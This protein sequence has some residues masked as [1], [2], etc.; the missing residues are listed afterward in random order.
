MPA[1]IRFI[2]RSVRRFEVTVWA[3][4]STQGGAMSLK[5]RVCQAMVEELGRER[6]YMLTGLVRFLHEPPKGAVLITPER[7][8]RAGGWRSVEI[9]L[10]EAR[11]SP[12]S[13]AGIAGLI[14]SL[15]SSLLLLCI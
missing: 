2:A 11:A 1:A 4:G 7:L 5:D 9:E 12:T 15:A 13:P 14:G 6:G 10:D 3:P 8:K